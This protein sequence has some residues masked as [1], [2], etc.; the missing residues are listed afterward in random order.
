MCRRWGDSIDATFVRQSVATNALN[1]LPAA[2]LDAVT[3]DSLKVPVVVWKQMLASRLAEDQS[4]PLGTSTAPALI[5]YGE[6]D[7]YAEEGPRLLAAALRQA[8]FLTYP[9]AGHAPHWDWPQRFT[10]DLHA[11]LA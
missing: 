10:D 5:L 1:P 11:F 4:P 9:V 6:Q 3:A 8:T 7:A 2:F